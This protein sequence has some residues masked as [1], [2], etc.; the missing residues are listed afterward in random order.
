MFAHRIA[1]WRDTKDYADCLP[2]PPRSQKFRWAANDQW[3]R[4]SVGMK[5]SVKDVDCLVACKQLIDAG[6]NPV[7]LNL[8][9]IL[10]PGGCVES[11]SGAQEESIFRRSNLNRTLTADFYPINPDEATYSADVSI[12]RAP[13]SQGHVF[14]SEPFKTSIISC[15]GLYRPQVDNSGRLTAKMVQQLEQ[16]LDLILKL[17]ACFGHDSIILGAMGC[18]GMHGCSNVCSNAL[19]IDS[20]PC[21]CNAAWQ[22]P[23]AEVAA[24]F[25]RVLQK[26][27]WGLQQVIVA[28]LSTGNH[29][30]EKSPYLSKKSN[31]QYF[32]EALLPDTTPVVDN[33]EIEED[34]KA[35]AA[36]SA[37][38]A[39]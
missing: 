8:A 10:V 9:D 29:G 13:E 39:V 26:D 37:L 24:A 2:P 35:E 18:G 5:V 36:I 12:F 17:A 19:C 7:V 34:R 6:S 32:C 28:C 31:Y 30:M 11:G 16:K 14:L 3:N 38:Q 4:P 23:P 1:V 21:W 15:P 20:E 27:C 33:D 25:A 22:N